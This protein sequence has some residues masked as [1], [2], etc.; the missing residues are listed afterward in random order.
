V[1]FATCSTGTAGCQ[2]RS[3]L[4][5]TAYAALSLTAPSSAPADGGLCTPHCAADADCVGGGQCN[6][7]Q[8]IASCIGESPDAGAPDA[9]Q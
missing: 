8:P 7:A 6:Q 4:A 5:C 1:C 2:G 9:G 3:E